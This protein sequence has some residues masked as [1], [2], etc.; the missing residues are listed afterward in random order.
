MYTHDLLFL[1]SKSRRRQKRKVSR[2][3]TFTSPRRQPAIGENITLQRNRRHAPQGRFL[4]T[5]L[6]SEE[7]LFLAIQGPLQLHLGKQKAGLCENVTKCRI[8]PVREERRKTNGDQCLEKARPWWGASI[9][10]AQVTCLHW[11]KG[12]RKVERRLLTDI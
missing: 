5:Q 8:S 12:R 7:H 11:T 1:G 3:I 9:I 10:R 4:A 2:V 6:L